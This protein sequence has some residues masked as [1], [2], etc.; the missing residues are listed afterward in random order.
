MVVEVEFPTS[1]DGRR[2][3]DQA[4]PLLV[5]ALEA[6]GGEAMIPFTKAFLREV[7]AVAKT[8]RM[9][10]PEGLL[11]AAGSSGSAGDEADES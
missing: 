9:E 10:L 3:L 7:D 1:P 5:V 2:R 4:S 11:E 6:D 8:I